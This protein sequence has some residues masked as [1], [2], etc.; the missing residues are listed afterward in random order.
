[1]KWVLGK[2]FQVIGM[3]G[4]LYARNDVAPFLS[5]LP[6]S[7]TKTDSCTLFYKLGRWSSS[8]DQQ[9]DEPRRVRCGQ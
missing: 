7:R 1:M 9:R 2:T 5:A 3:L 4:A 6:D 8:A